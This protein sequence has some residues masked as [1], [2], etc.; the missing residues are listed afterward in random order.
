MIFFSSGTKKNLHIPTIQIL[1]LLEYKKYPNSTTNN[2]Q[3]P[4]FDKT[5][6]SKAQKKQSLSKKISKQQEPI[7]AYNKGYKKSK[8]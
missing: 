1:D 7:N 2:I 3:S 5:Q 8:L 6:Q 4:K